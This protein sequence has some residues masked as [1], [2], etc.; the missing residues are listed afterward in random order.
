MAGR[1]GQDEF[2]LRRGEVTIGDVDGD[3]LFTLRA[4]AVG[5]QSEIDL[6]AAAARTCN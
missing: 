6:A 3:A 4:Q 1:V 5:E 2:A